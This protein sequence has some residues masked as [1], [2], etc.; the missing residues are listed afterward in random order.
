MSIHAITEQVTE[1]VKKKNQI[2][3]AVALTLSCLTNPAYDLEDRWQLYLQIVNN[4]LLDNIELFGDGFID[5]LGGN[6]TIYDNFYA[7]RYQTVEYFDMWDTILEDE[8]GT[9]ETRDEWREKVLASGYSGFKYD[10]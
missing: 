4:N 9:S 8:H 7:E 10:W 1:L 5:T 3:E 6:L 2:D